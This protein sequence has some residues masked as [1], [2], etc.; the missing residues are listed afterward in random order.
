MNDIGGLLEVAF[1]AGAVVLGAA[2]VFGIVSYNRR[3]RAN[4]PITD[5]ATR[6]LYADTDTYGAKEDDL[7]S[8]THS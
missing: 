7:R 5:E 6:E 1:F 8:R 4:E 2:L 3:N